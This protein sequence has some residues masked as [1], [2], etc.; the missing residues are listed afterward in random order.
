MGT[1]TAP[2]PATTPISE[3]PPR[4]T[5]AY[6]LLINTLTHTHSSPT[7]YRT[8]IMQTTT[9]FLMRQI[10]YECNIFQAPPYQPGFWL[11]NMANILTNNIILSFLC[12]MPPNNYKYSK[13]D[14][15]LYFLYLKCKIDAIN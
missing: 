4:K 2:P 12:I 11:K 7:M 8:T 6:Q 9:G 1:R 13:F 5:T 14:A 15:V 10:Y 3:E